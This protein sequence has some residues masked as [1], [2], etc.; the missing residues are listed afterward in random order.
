[1][2]SSVDTSLKNAKHDEDEKRKANKEIKD[3]KIYLDT[4][5]KDKEIPQSVKE[6][7]SLIGEVEKIINVGRAIPSQRDVSRAA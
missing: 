5:E 3:L 2:V 6:F 4:M 7:S 1:M